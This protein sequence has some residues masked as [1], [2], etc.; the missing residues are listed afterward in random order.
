MKT[1]NVS[2][3]EHYVISCLVRSERGPGD[4]VP[5]FTHV[6]LSTQPHGRCAARRARRCADLDPQPRRPIVPLRLHVGDF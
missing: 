3:G 4:F 2:L 6:E 5:P 1:S